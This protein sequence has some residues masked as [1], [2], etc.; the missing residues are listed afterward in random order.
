MIA[1]AWLFGLIVAIVVIAVA[2]AFLNRFY[3]KSTRDVALVRTGF[4]G[5]KVVLSGGCLALPFLHKVEEIN[6]SEQRNR[7]MQLEYETIKK[8]MREM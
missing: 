4:G 1:L 3:R 5:Q 6:I 7:A 2:V 8:K